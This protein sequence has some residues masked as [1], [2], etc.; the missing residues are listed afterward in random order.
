MSVCQFYQL[1]SLSVCK[2]CQFVTVCQFCQFVSLSVCQWDLALWVEQ[3]ALLMSTS[4]QACIAA[5]IELHKQK[6]LHQTSATY[7]HTCS[8]P[9]RRPAKPLPQN[10]NDFAVL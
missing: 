7:F 5:V 8:E 4:G 10:A 3:E 6:S 2:F 1:V 9:W